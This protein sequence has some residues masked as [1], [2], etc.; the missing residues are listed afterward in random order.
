MASAHSYFKEKQDEFKNGLKPDKE[1]S[2]EIKRI[3]NTYV[4]FSPTYKVYLAILMRL[5]ILLS[6]LVISSF[7]GN[8]FENKK[9]IVVSI[10]CLAFFTIDI[11]R[12][13]Y[14]L[15]TESKI[16]L[17]ALGNQVS[18]YLKKLGIE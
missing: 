1:Q 17:E 14:Y 8:L 10:L 2:K 6:V 18:S 15:L 4:S 9:I 5:M 3:F 13:S 7:I 12:L 11:F 16:D